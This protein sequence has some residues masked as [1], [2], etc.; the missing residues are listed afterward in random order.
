MDFLRNF[1]RIF[2]TFQGLLYNFLRNVWGPSEDLL[3]IFSRLSQDSLRTSSGLYLDLIKTFSRL[4][5]DFL[6]TFSGLSQDFLG[7]VWGSSQDFLNT[8]PG[9]YQN[10]FNTYRVCH[11]LPWPCLFMALCNLVENVF[12]FSIYFLYIVWTNNEYYNEYYNKS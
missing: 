9:H 2:V 1:L 11:W 8:F 12:S 4:A 6:R 5:Q 10:L 3:R 7:T